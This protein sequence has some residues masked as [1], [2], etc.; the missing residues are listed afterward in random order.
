MK[1][2]RFV[3][4]VTDRQGRFELTI[5]GQNQFRL[6]PRDGHRR[7][8]HHGNLHLD[9]GV[10]HVL[11]VAPVVRQMLVVKH[12]HDFATALKRRRDLVKETPPR[13]HV[14][15]GF[16]GGRVIAVFANTD[17]AGDLHFARAQRDGLVDRL[18]DGKAVLLSQLAAQIVLR[19][20]IR[21]QRHKFQVGALAAGLIKAVQDFSE[22]HVGMRVLVIRSDDRRHR[23][24]FP[25]RFV[26]PTPRGARRQQRRRRR[27]LQPF[28]SSKVRHRFALSQVFAGRSFRAVGQIIMREIKTRFK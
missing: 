24:F 23:K 2:V 17:H 22:D 27:R 10:V 7:A 18:D 19:R 21:I 12:R 20:L 26:A 6:A 11:G 13:I 5:L 9:G 1:A 8:G 15:L 3:A 28:A 4:A 16:F 14:L 25:G